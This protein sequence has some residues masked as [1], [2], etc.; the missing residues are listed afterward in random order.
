MDVVNII[1]QVGFPIFCVLGLGW[2]SKY[3]FDKANEQNDKSL[4]KIGNL[5]EA[6]NHNSEVI[7]DLVREIHDNKEV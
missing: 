6:V 1:S 4:E 2:W 3:T 5:T 7:V